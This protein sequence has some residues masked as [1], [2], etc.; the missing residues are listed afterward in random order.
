VEQRPRR[1][2]WRRGGDLGVG[3]GGLQVMVVVLL[4]VVMVTRHHR[5]RVSGEGGTPS[6]RTRTSTSTS[7][8]DCGEGQRLRCL[9]T[10]GHRLGCSGDWRCGG[11][12]TEQWLLRLGGRGR[13]VVVVVV[14]VVTHSRRR[15][16]GVDEGRGG[17]RHG[18]RGAKERQSV[19]F[20]RVNLTVYAQRSA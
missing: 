14:M 8:G 10:R 17:A 7:V 19:V 2:R 3:L 18:I 11:R 15:F 16:R 9:A 4:V 12:R 20:C 5:R 13:E 1:L 6:T